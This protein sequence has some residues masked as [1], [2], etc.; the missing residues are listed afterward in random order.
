MI[1]R[2]CLESDKCGGAVCTQNYPLHGLGKV[3]E[4]F[5]GP[6]DLVVGSY[7]SQI[8]TFLQSV[9]SAVGRWRLLITDHPP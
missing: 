1:L 9:G 2:R 3:F 6:E 4:T 7:L 5:D 8:T